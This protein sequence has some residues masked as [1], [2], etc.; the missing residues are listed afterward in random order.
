MSTLVLF[1]IGTKWNAGLIEND[2]FSVGGRS[3]Q[4]VF[5]QGSQLNLES[6]LW[7]RLD[8]GYHAALKALL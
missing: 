4:K 7:D 8:S 2:E 5:E 3:A 6:Q 1:T